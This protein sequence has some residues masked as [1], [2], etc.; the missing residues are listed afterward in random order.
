[1]KYYIGA[2]HAGIEIKAFVKDLFEQ[3]G[4]E[5]ID[6][7]P[8]SKDRVDYPDFAEKVCKK[9]LEDVGSMGILICGSGLGMSMAAN[10]FDGIRAALCHNE[11]SAKMAR[12]HN[13]AN[14]LCLGERV[15][16]EGM[17]EAI[18]KAWDK[19]EFEGGR[20]TQRVEKINALGKMGSCRA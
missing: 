4:H 1:M 14:I 3:R 15:S 17:I 12:K 18:I 6:M 7:G 9:V 20:H 2:D 5:V 11:Y 10:K 19:A 8:Y 13:D 16:G